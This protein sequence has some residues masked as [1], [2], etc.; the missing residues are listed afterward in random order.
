MMPHQ[1]GLTIMLPDTLP[2]PALMSRP[3]PLLCDTTLFRISSPVPTWP[4]LATT[5]S[6]P[7]LAK[8]S[9]QS[10]TVSCSA[11]HSVSACR[12][13]MVCLE[14]LLCHS[15]MLC[16][17]SNS[18]DR[19]LPH[20]SQKFT[21]SRSRPGIDMLFLPLLRGLATCKDHAV[22]LQDDRIA[23]GL[24]LHLHSYSWE[25]PMT[26]LYCQCLNQHPSYQISRHVQ[27]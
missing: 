4:L 24:D 11:Q 22:M 5:E 10:L 1:A 15:G 18:C 17:I 23:R 12:A 25:D 16:S 27:T 20:T 9:G 2:P 3:R 7:T 13:H 6:K 21:F 26:H 19:G 8:P 14:R